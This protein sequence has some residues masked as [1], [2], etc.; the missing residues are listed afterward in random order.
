MFYGK[1]LDSFCPMGSV[2][3]DRAEA[4]DWRDFEIVCRVND[5]ERQR[6][7]VANMIFPVP[8]LIAELSR[9]L[10]LEPGDLI[11]TGTPAGCGYQMTPARFLDVGDVVECS[12]SGLG[13]MVNPV[14]SYPA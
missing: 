1:G 7:S 14:A 6:E 3:V 10:T 5:E 9:G 4:G 11:S 13:R 12:A 2:I 8:R